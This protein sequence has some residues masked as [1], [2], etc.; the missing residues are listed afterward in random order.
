MRVAW[1]GAAERMHGV[2]RSWAVVRGPASAA[3]ASLPRIGWKFVKPFTV[4]SDIGTRC[5]LMHIS[6]K[7]FLRRLHEGVDRWAWKRALGQMGVEE[8]NKE[9]EEIEATRAEEVNGV[10]R[11]TVE[12]GATKACGQEAKEGR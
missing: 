10:V 5:E 3:W 1:R 6:P 7:R 4:E 8:E 11:V 12:S 9:A 2:K